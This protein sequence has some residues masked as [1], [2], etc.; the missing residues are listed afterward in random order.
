MNLVEGFVKVLAV[1]GGAALGF[2][3][4]G[5]L[6]RFFGKRVGA[7]KAP[8]HMILIVRLLGG[9]VAGWLV[10]LMV[11][12]PGGS[13]LFGGGGSLFGG[14]GTGEGTDDHTQTMQTSFASTA[15]SSTPSTGASALQVVILGGKRVTEGRFYFVEGEKMAL[16]LEEL[17]QLIQD[18]HSQNPALQEIEIKLYQNSVASE[19]WA[20]TNLER[21]ATKNQFTVRRPP[22]ESQDFP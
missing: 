1:V 11:T 9:L 16:T 10:W 12:A 14:R 2:I 13:G 20:V 17:K 22:P 7:A 8:R 5:L 4:I 15:R 3:G 6:I 19:H 21:W 18:R